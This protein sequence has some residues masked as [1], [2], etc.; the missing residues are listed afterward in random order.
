MELIPSKSAQFL[1]GGYEDDDYEGGYGIPPASAL[2]IKNDL[3]TNERLFR[4]A[5]H[6]I[7]ENLSRNGRFSAEWDENQM[8][9]VVTDNQTNQVIWESELFQDTYGTSLRWSPKDESRLA[10]LRGKPG[11]RSEFITELITLTIVDVVTGK[12]LGSY[13]GDFGRLEWSPDGQKILYEAP[14]TYYGLAFT[15]AP[16]ILFLNIGEKRCLRSIPR[17]VPEG[18]D[19]TTTGVYKWGLS[20][21]TIYYTYIYGKEGNW[22]GNLCMYS[23]VTS[24]II[25]PTENLEALRGMTIIDHDI[26]P[27]QQFL[28]FCYSASSLLNDYADTAYDGVIKV[29]GSGFFSWKGLVQIGGPQVCSPSTLWRPL[30]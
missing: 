20:N 16:C 13:A 18:Y 25:C 12:V 29:D 6:G 30:P 19:L 28:Y 8:G 15:D 23:L 21:E 27:D 11:E 2:Q 3:D 26:S 7:Y 4:K 24:Y 9:I 17:L 14:I 1:I 5:E 10:Y 22:I